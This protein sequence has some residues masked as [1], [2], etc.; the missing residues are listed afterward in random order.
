MACAHGPAFDHS[1]VKDDIYLDSS[2]SWMNN[3]PNNAV[4]SLR[5]ITLRVIN[6][7]YRDVDVKVKC[8]FIDD[9]SLFGEAVKTVKA[10]NDATLMVRGFSR[11][12]FKDRVR[13]TIKS[14]R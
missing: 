12:P 10:R 14:Y 11:A 13:C 9:G 3:T 5:A 4:P 7:K 8:I 1:T 6:K 2:Y